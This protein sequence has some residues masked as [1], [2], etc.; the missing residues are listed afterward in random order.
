MAECNDRGLTKNVGI[1]DI[2]AI[3]EHVSKKKKTKIVKTLSF[4]KAL[5]FVK[6]L[7][8]VRTLSFVKTL[9]FKKKKL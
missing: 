6:T 9:S 1:W 4:V 3:C 2:C 8:F 5:S 7:S